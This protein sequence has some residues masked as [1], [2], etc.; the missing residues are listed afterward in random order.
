MSES[1]SAAGR[2]AILEA[3]GVHKWFGRSHVLR[4]IDLRVFPGEIVCLIGPSG[5][6]KSTFLRCINNLEQHDGGVI[7]IDGTP[8]GYNDENGTLYRKRE[9]DS[10]NLRATC[11]MV[12]QQFHLF[13]HMNA[14]Q[15]VTYGPRQVKGMSRKQADD[16]G[17]SLLS[18]VGLEGKMDSYPS[19]LSGGQQQRVAIARA[20]AMEPDLMLFDEPTSALDPELV[21]EVLTVMENLANDGMTMIVVTHE[22]GFARDLAH[23][24]AF[25]DQGQII[26]RGTREM[27][28]HPNEPRTATFLSRMNQRRVI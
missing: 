25:M 22:I 1:V 21:G 8:V 26:E 28:D 10:A 15:N 14:L 17:R 23:L 7:A 19:K 12:F 16:L 20:L 11:G 13:P 18:R 24:V 3:A 5:S 2:S 4:G 9:K 27:L 6:G